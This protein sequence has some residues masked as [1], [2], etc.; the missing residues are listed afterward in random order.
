MKN[1]NPVQP[2]IPA[3]APAKAKTTKP[4]APAPVEEV[5][6]TEAAAPAGRT[7][8]NPTVELDGQVLVIEVPVIEEP[9]LSGSNKTFLVAKMNGYKTDIKINGETVTVNLN[10]FIKNRAY[11]PPAK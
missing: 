5:E 10:A 3:A 8:S 11:V 7:I 1:P 2:A 4:A 9:E 6:E